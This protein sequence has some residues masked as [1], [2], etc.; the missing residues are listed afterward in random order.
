MWK[1]KT[2]KSQDFQTRPCTR[3]N[4]RMQ[5]VKNRNKFLLQIVREHEVALAPFAPACSTNRS[6]LQLGWL[7]HSTLRDIVSSMMTWRAL[8][9]QRN[10]RR[11]LLE[12]TECDKSRRYNPQRR[13]PQRLPQ[14]GRERERHHL[15]I[16]P[17]IHQRLVVM[18]GVWVKISK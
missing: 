11:L 7:L 4:E 1:H 16:H 6:A 13:H 17:R 18:M 10:S 2:H 14:S 5:P 15:E 9:M 8:V 12:S 3:Y